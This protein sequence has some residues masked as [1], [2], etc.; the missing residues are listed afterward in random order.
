MVRGVNKKL[1]P[2]VVN[3][4][5][6]RVFE[7][8]FGKD[9][10]VQVNCVRNTDNIQQLQRKRKIYKQRYE[11]FRVQNHY[12]EYKEYITIGSR[13]RCDRRTVEAET[14]YRE[15]LEQTEEEWRRQKELS[16]TS[17]IGVA[18]VSFR[19]RDCVAQ[20]IDEIDIVKSQPLSDFCELLH[21][22]DWE[23]EQASPVNDIIWTEMNKGRARSLLVRLLLTLLPLLVAAAVVFGSVFI[24]RKLNDAVPGYLTV[25]LKYLL[26][27]ALVVFTLYILPA[28]V[29]LVVKAERHER[30][31]TREDTLT[32]M[33]VATMMLSMLVLPFVAN[34]I[35]SIIDREDHL[36]QDIS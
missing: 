3:D 4:M 23:V 11:H 24:D 13:L 21:I 17:N 34:A 28:V 10:V 9:S 30:V 29:F 18:F 33:T 27:L 6:A 26:S 2:K 22:K 15:K 12:Q 36:T 25:G 7:D 20:T 19:N 32:F 14:Y 16:Q 1:A 8:R 5:I 31:S 35:L